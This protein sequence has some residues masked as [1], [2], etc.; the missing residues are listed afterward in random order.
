MDDKR[1]DVINSGENRS[2]T[3]NKQHIA[4][5]VYKGYTADGLEKA[6]KVFKK[7]IQASGLFKELKDRRYYEKPGDRKRRKIRENARRRRKAGKL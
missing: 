2:I 4:V 1:Q 3:D 5:K 7:K 6:L